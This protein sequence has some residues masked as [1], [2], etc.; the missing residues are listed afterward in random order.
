M[1]DDKFMRTWLA[2]AYR[3]AQDSPDLSTQNG[4]ILIGKDGYTIGKGFNTLPHGVSITQ[5]RLERPA[6]Y[7]WTE[8]AERNALFNAAAFGFATPGST[9]VC[10][11]AACV[12]CARAMIQCGVKTLITHQDAYDR[13]PPHWIDSIAVAYEMFNESGLEVIFYK[14]HLNA[15]TIRHNGEEWTP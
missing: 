3:I 12:D 13:S 6:K 14:G 7:L 10:P 5:E 8:H 9:M 15:R 2:E 11:W 1:F 4:A